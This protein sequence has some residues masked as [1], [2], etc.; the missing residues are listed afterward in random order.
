MSDT[1]E[2]GD[3]V[4][5]VDGSGELTIVAGPFRTFRT[6][7]DES[8]VINT[9]NDCYRWIKGSSLLPF[10][11]ITWTPRMKREM[12]SWVGEAFEKQVGWENV[13]IALRD[14]IYGITES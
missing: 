10:A 5:Y 9:G 1:F 7:P 2:I 14:R 4:T 6:D 13:Y 12:R 8:Y 3:E 11:P